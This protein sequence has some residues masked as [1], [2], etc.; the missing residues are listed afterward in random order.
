MITVVGG[1]PERSRAA[2]AEDATAD[3]EAFLER[4]RDLP[5]RATRVHAESLERGFE[6]N[7]GFRGGHPV[8]EV[9]P[10]GE[11]AALDRGLAVVDAPSRFEEAATGLAAAGAQVA[12]N[13]TGEGVPTGHPVVPV[14][15]VSADE[16][17]LAAL[18]D[19]VDVDATTVSPGGLTERVLAVANGERTCA[20][21]HGRTEFAITRV[22][23]SM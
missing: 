18:P 16:D 1:I 15:K 2:A 9:V 5:A 3:V 21:R 22:G 17:A 8:R 12:V 11:V 23:P 10:Y 7:T 19:D 14:L 13:V 4:H 20:E 6:D